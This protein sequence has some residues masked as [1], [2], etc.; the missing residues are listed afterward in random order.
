M[1]QIEALNLASQALQSSMFQLAQNVADPALLNVH[2]AA[3]AMMEF[4]AQLETTY[5]Q[6][7][8]CLSAPGLPGSRVSVCQSGPFWK[9]SEVPAA[10]SG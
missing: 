6:L 9:P 5:T 7:Q 8:V 4:S 1:V 3:D 10:C 2:S